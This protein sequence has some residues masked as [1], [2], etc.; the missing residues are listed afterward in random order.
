M[1]SN[2]PLVTIIIPIYNAD[3]YLKKCISSVCYQTY[4]NLEIILVD[5]GSTDN[6]AIICNKFSKQDKRIR[7]F[8]RENQGVSAARNFGI[9]KSNGV[10]IVFLDSDDWLPCSGIQKLVEG[11]YNNNADLCYGE[12]KLIGSIYEKPARDTENLH[13]SGKDSI[14]MLQ[15]MKNI[16]PGPCAKIYKATI[17]KSMTEQFPLGIKFGEDTI[18]LYRYIQKCNRF[19]SI[20][21]CVYFY[22][23][24]NGNAASR[25]Q[26]EEMGDWLLKQIEELVGIFRGRILSNVEKQ[27]I[28]EQLY[29]VYEISSKHYTQNFCRNFG[30]ELLNNTKNKYLLFLNQTHMESVCGLDG[31]SIEEKIMRYGDELTTEKRKNALY[32]ILIPFISIIKKHLIFT[33]RIIH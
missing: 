15:Y 31:I 1:F 28:T 26:Y 22:N 6:S 10:Y 33:F 21:D 13:F 2:L 14:F 30:L 18:F 16:Y 25:K 17:V 3:S 20:H 29:K 7:I 9:S 23:Q 32:K 8:N 4:T 11:I 12:T 5:D 19:S 24:L 27:Y